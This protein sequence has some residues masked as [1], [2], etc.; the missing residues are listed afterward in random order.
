MCNELELTP[1]PE[2]VAQRYLDLGYWQGQT[3]GE[4]L[5]ERAAKTP[6]N[7]AIVCGSRSLSYHDVLQASYVLAVGFL[8]N[9]IKAKDAVVIQLPNVAE[10]FTVCFALF[11]IGARPVFALPAH[12]FSEINHLIESTQ[13]VGYVIAEDRD[14]D[15]RNLAQQLKST[16]MCLKHVWV[17][18]DPGPWV[19]LSELSAQAGGRD[20]AQL[21]NQLNEHAPSARDLAM[22]QLSGGSTGLPKLIPRTHDDYLYSVRASADICRLTEGSVYLSVLP[23][24]HNFSLSSPGSLGVFYAGGCVVLSRY[25]SADVAFPLIEKH[26]VNLAAVVPSLALAWLQSARKDARQL[27]SLEVLQVGG[28]KFNEAS[29]RSV[30]LIMG[31]QL[32]QVFGMAEGLVCYTRWYD[33]EDLIC[34]TQG[35]AISIDDEIRVVDD[36]DQ[37]VAVGEVGHLLTRGPYTIRGYYKAAKHNQN[38][39]TDDGFYRTGDVVRQSEMGYVVVEGRAK[40]QINRGGE[41]IAAQE[42]EAHLLVHAAVL[43]AALVGV[44]DEYLGERSC[45]FVVVREPIRSMSLKMFLHERGLAQYK[46]PDRIEF[47]DYLPKTAVG[48]INKLLLR[49]MAEQ[50]QNERD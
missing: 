39:F 16:A 17:V 27:E 42:V 7:T 9:G 45:A 14:F 44:A 11:H 43:D 12:R 1:W 35:R 18:G 25:A 48:K 32:Q 5:E 49:Q 31:C 10:F 26:R 19:A 13:A 2:H 47:V 21:L 6:N 33:S 22:L 36:L 15:Y 50:A 30:R 23:V 38:A 41:K 4:M 40:D 20:T 28:A 29:A 24:A 46:I 34:Q 3:I 37:E 8:A